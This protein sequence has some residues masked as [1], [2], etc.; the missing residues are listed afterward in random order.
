LA[1]ES[2]SDSDLLPITN[3]FNK[4]LRPKDSHVPLNGFPLDPSDPTF[5]PN[6]PSS[7]SRHNGSGDV[8][9]NGRRGRPDEGLDLRGLEDETRVVKNNA[10]IL[11]EA[12]AFG[13][14]EETE[15][16]LVGVS[17]CSGSSNNVE[18]VSKLLIGIQIEMSTLSDTVVKHPS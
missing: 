7:H 14:D 10:K 2:K 15:G 8:G 11:S 18:G 17:I 4:S 5:D 6:P 3:L 1:W 13:G 16:E 9:I 12:L